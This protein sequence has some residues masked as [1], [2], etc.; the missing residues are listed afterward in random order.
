META[1]IILDFI[2]IGAAAWAIYAVKDLG[3]IVGQA[4]IYIMWGMIFLG[5]AHI[6]E[7]ITFDMLGW[8]IVSVEI[9]HRAVVLIGFVFLVLGFRQVQQLKM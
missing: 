5:L 8:H 7:T 6:S 3:G 2:L 9:F 4:F 1:I